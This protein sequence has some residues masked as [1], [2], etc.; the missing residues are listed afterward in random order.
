MRRA[1][2]RLRG[3]RPFSIVET[4]ASS[5]RFFSHGKNVPSTWTFPHRATGTTWCATRTAATRTRVSVG[6]NPCRGSRNPRQHG[7]MALGKLQYH[8]PNAGML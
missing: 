1:E 6:G 7:S 3:H 5:R 2:K 8:V 4:A